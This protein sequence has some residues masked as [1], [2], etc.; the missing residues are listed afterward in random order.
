MFIYSSLSFALFSQKRCAFFFLPFM[1][2]GNFF[3][4]LFNQNVALPPSPFTY[5]LNNHFDFTQGLTRGVIHSKKNSPPCNDVFEVDSQVRLNS[6][7]SLI[8][9]WISVGRLMFLQILFLKLLAYY[10][11]TVTRRL[12]ISSRGQPRPGFALQSFFF[13]F[14]GIFEST[15]MKYL[16]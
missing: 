9:P 13:V 16:N 10:F 12:S 5:P 8:H 14:T 2:P 1:L 15:C 6:V 3:K 7:E 11:R 4:F